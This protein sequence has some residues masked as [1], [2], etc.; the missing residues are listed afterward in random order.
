MTYQTHAC[1]ACDHL[2]VVFR[3]GEVSCKQ[4][5]CPSGDIFG[6]SFEDFCDKLDE[7][8]LVEYPRNLPEAFKQV[9]RE[10]A[11]RRMGYN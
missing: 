11:L 2:S 8:E 1:P 7:A 6:A 4:G 10:N 9:M 3:D 5:F